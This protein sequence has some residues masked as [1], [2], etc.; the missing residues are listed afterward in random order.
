MKSEKIDIK[1]DLLLLLLV[2]A[3]TVIFNDSVLTAPLRTTLFWG[4]IG[5]ILLEV[6]FITLFNQ[7]SQ[8][9]ISKYSNVLMKIS[10]KDRFFPYFFLPAIFYISLLFFLF[11]NRNVILGNIVLGV[12]MVFLLILFLNVKSSLKRYYSVHMLTRTIFDFLCI[13]I[14]YLLLNSYLRIGVSLEIYTIL[15]FLSSFVLSIFVLK[16][17]DRMEGPEI[18]TAIVTSIFVAVSM[19]LFWNKNLFIIPA[20]GSLMFYLV[21][22][23]WNIRFAGRTKFEDYLSPVLYVIFAI[24]LILVM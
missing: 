5:L 1:K 16:L 2:L 12:S 19:I 24:I 20:I 7:N 15:A 4:V 17:H 9:K 22:S 8:K 23:I 11:F 13:T 14:F 3:V 18:G 10:L 21:I 6:W